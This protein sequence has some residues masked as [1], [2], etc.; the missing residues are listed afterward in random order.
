MW[1]KGKR[2]KE[3]Y[4]VDNYVG[5][6]SKQVEIVN[7]NPHPM[8]EMDGNLTDQNE[9]QNEEQNEDISDCEEHYYER[10]MGESSSNMESEESS[11]FQLRQPLYSD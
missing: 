8:E 1:L 7:Y 5:G 6:I 3:R 11:V 9:E 2:N 4:N 10:I